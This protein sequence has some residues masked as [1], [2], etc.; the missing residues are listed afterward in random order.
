[1]TRILVV[2]DEER[3]SSFLEK[4]LRANGYV[5]TVVDDGD[6]AAALLRTEDQL[7]FRLRRRRLDA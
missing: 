4:G 7:R 5:P 2:E 3:I 1:M 6:R